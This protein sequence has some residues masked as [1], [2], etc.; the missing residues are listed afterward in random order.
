MEGYLVLADGTV[1]KG[2]SFGA[3]GPAVSEGEVVFNTSMTGYQELLTDP[4][5][6]GQI[7]TLTYPLAGNYG[8]NL[9]DDE[10][11]RIQVKGLVVR[12]SCESPSHWQREYT[13]GQWLKSQNI[14]G[15]SGIDTR[16]LTR[17]IRRYGTMNGIIV[18]GRR[19][20][21]ELERMAQ[22]LKESTGWEGCDLT[23]VVTADAPYL[24]PYRPGQ[25]DSDPFLDGSLVK[26]VRPGDLGP[27]QQGVPRLVVVDYGVKRN[28]LRN[29]AGYGCELVVVPQNASAESI[30]G[31]DPDGIVLSNG[32][33]DPKEVRGAIETVRSLLATRIPTL[34]ICL[35]HQILGLAL[36]GNTRKMLF[37]HR[38][39]N[40][41][42]KDLASGKIY[43]TSQNHGYML[44][45]ESLDPS[46]IE[47]TAMNGNDGTLEGFRHRELPIVSIQYHPEGNP[48][49]DD[50][51]Y[52]YKE[53]FDLLKKR[54][55]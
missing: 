42:V 15:L 5:Y 52:L 47:I 36:G 44:E 14:I 29:L 46:V 13:L 39:G 28:I 22:N 10:S 20:E 25:G 43:I 37:G 4:S 11:N 17:K 27:K 40:H 31:Y 32:P 54:T 9:I 34:G 55:A 23:A 6:S 2:E 33:G 26:D 35:G 30:I 8:V 48:G 3:E 12:E 18:S 41:P 45:E 16:S 49:P 24:I 51:K 19:T 50:S 38:G 1:Y 7:V 53:F 21:Q